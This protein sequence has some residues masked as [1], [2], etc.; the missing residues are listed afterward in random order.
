MHMPGHK[1]R[2]AFSLNS[3]SA[4]ISPGRAAS[5]L[6]EL[7]AID[8]TESPGLDN[9]HY[10]TGC[11]RDTEERAARF[12]GSARTFFLVNG[13][14]SGIQASLL[15]VR[16]TLGP[17][18]VVLPRNV[19]KSLV[20]AMVMSGLEPVFVWPEYEP[21]FGSYLPLDWP[22]VKEVLTELVDKGEPV[23][24]AVFVFNPTYSGFAR[25][26]TEL[27]AEVYARG[28][29]LLVDEA[30][31]THFPVGEGLPPTALRSGADLITHGAHKTTVAFTQTAFLHVG[32][33]APR[34]FPDLLPAVEEALRAVQSTSPSYILMASLEQAVQVLERDGGEWVNRGTRIAGELASRIGKIPG[35]SVAGYQNGGFPSGLMHDPSKVLVDLSGLGV[36]GPEA[37]RYVV[38]K[39]AVVPEMVGPRYI[40]LLV[41]GAH[42]PADVDAVESAFKE[43]ADKFPGRG[44]AEP[45]AAGDG[46]DG[47]ICSLLREIPHPTRVMELRRA[48]LSVSRPV[49]VEE[50]AGKIAADTVVIYP[51]GSPLITPGERIDRDVVEYILHA[52]KAGLNVLGRGIR[53]GEGEMRVYC[54]ASS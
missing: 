35:L 50:A 49:P 42:G 47:D 3:S 40:L 22:R 27:S 51:P 15:A 38:R 13:A 5:L 45:V 25:D 11:I 54:V 18:T 19:H 2:K 53:S 41:S 46:G 39:C 37:A 16:M 26:L 23:P 34:R 6:D 14:T 8:M 10:P 7:R 24:R 33:S 30:H 29:A 12:F 4:A 21:R 1:G 43:L 36:G 48:F 31:G 32:V 44:A 17:G 20:S 28:M 9:L 52:R